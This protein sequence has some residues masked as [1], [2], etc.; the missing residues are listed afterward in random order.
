MFLRWKSAEPL[1]RRM[2]TTFDCSICDPYTAAC[3]ADLGVCLCRAYW[4]GDNC[5]ESII[6]SNEAL[7]KYFLAHTIIFCVLFGGI[8]AF[9][10]AEIINLVSS[11]FYYL[12]SAWLCFD[13]FVL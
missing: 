10:L 2:N 1:N 11:L 7:A 13:R 5:S 4:Q 3:R 8:I 6:A 9:G 12:C